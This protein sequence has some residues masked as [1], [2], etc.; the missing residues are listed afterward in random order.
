MSWVDSTPSTWRRS[1]GVR[2]GDGD[3]R[4][5]TNHKS[6]GGGEKL[7]DERGLVASLACIVFGNV[8]TAEKGVGCRNLNKG[9]L[10]P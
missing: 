3:N 10:V 8:T 9:H 7:G 6:D 2:D 1:G 4:Y 5:D